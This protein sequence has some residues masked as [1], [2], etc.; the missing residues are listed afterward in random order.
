MR[1]RVKLYLRHQPARQRWR[2]D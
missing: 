2:H 1:V